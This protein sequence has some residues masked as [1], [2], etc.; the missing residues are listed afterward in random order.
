MLTSSLTVKVDKKDFIHH[1]GKSI[2]VLRNIEFSIQN[3]EL[4]V[5]TGPSGCGKTTLLNLI[6]GLDSDYRGHIELPSHSDDVLPLSYVFQKPYLLPWR[7]LKE[8][9]ML[10]LK[11]P[12]QR[13]EQITSL[14]EEMGIADAAN[15]YPTTLSLGMARRTA[16]ARAFAVKAPL[17]LMDE[18]FSSI[19]ELTANRLRQL[20]LSQL[21]ILPHVVIFVTHNL[22]EALFLGNRLLIMSKQPSTIAADLPLPGKRGRSSDKIEAL[23]K[24]ILHQFPDILG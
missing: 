5:I 10:A 16:L 12:R 23:H 13:E 22:R 1:D 19:D 7:T 20:L 4:L 2:P 14:L 6:A 3:H 24:E 8:N 18:A 17:L 15:S 21:E 11:S 9:I